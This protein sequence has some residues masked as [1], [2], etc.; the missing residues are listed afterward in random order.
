MGFPI[1][2]EG[3]NPVTVALVFSIEPQTL[4]YLGDLLA[5]SDALPFDF[6]AAFA[7]LEKTM[8][9]KIDDLEASMTKLNADVE[10]AVAAG[11]TFNDKLTALQT[12]NKTLQDA[13]AVL[14]SGMDADEAELDKARQTIDAATARIAELTAA[15][16]GTVP[17][18]TPTPT[19]PDVVVG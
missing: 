10:T 19:P 5:R 9:Q 11:A 14:Q 8:T 1:T 3:G 12:A 4:K 18:P 2:L 16:G 15:L 17:T 13:N 7:A 6:A